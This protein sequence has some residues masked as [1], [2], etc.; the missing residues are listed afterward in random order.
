[1]AKPLRNTSTLPPLTPDL[2]LSERI[3]VVPDTKIERILYKMLLDQMQENA[4]LR[5]K[6]KQLKNAKTE[7]RRRRA[8]ADKI[9]RA[10][11]G[12]MPTGQAEKGTP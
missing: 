3:K 7:G 4:V 10:I 2:A 12:D 8:I 5:F 6:L 9:K 1:V 11:G